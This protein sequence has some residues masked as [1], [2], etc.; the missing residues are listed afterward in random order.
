MDK[1]S[2]VLLAIMSQSYSDSKL[3]KNLIQYRKNALASKN[4]NHLDDFILTYDTLIMGL[5]IQKQ[6]VEDVDVLIDLWDQ[7]VERLKVI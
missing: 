1:V 2:A 3:K 5:L 7:L 4:I 6:V